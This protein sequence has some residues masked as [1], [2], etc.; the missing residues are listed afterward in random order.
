MFLNIKCIT[1]QYIFYIDES[2]TLL[3]IVAFFVFGICIQAGEL[4]YSG[5]FQSGDFSL[6][7]EHLCALLPVSSLP[8]LSGSEM[9]E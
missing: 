3:D 7:Q 2:L 6:Q 4:S 1:F 5:H 9:R 8:C